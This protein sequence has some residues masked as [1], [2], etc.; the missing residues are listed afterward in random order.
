MSDTVIGP[1]PG[2]NG[3]PF[4]LVKQPS[5]DTATYPQIP[6]TLGV[7]LY[8]RIK[9]IKLDISF[10]APPTITIS[11]QPTAGTH[12]EKGTLDADSGWTPADP[13]TGGGPQPWQW[14][15]TGDFL[16]VETASPYVDTMTEKNL[17]RGSSH[18]SSAEHSSSLPI[19]YG[20][21]GASKTVTLDTSFTSSSFYYLSDSQLSLRKDLFTFS[22]PCVLQC[23]QTPTARAGANLVIGLK[24]TSS[25]DTGLTTF[26]PWGPS[27]P[28]EMR[29]YSRSVVQDLGQCGTIDLLGNEI[30]LFASI[31]WGFSRVP[32]PAQAWKT[33]IPVTGY[34]TDA[35][36]TITGCDWW[37]Y[38]NSSGNPVWSADTGAPLAGVS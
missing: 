27:T 14:Y 19:G 26:L 8:R 33:D 34:C 3:F 37:P 13:S 7:V 25:S 2:F 1:N 22:M 32:V 38:K 28:P 35:S 11:T 29:E 18:P 21:S 31:S 6:Y 15:G 36:A 20:G 5:T 17:V 24:G 12:P 30:P 10:G 16:P 23:Y 4:N 9:R